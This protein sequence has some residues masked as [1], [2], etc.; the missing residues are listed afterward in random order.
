MNAE[1]FSASGGGGSA[2]GGGS[3]VAWANFNGTGTIAIRAS[4][5]CS[6]ITDNGTGNYT[7]NMTNPMTDANCAIAVIGDSLEHSTNST[8][9]SSTS[10]SVRFA[11]LKVTGGTYYDPTTVTVIVVR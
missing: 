11:T 8:W 3:I 1:Q 6:S 7:L 5:N 2:G 9:I 10:S 4:G